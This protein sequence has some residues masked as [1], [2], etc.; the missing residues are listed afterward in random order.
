VRLIHVSRRTSFQSVSTSIAVYYYPIAARIFNCKL[1]Q[2]WR[3][4]VYRLSTINDWKRK[5]KRKREAKGK[6]QTLSLYWA[7]A[8]RKHAIRAWL[9]QSSFEHPHCAPRLY[10]DVSTSRLAIVVEQCFRLAVEC[11]DLPLAW[12]FGDRDDSTEEKQRS[13]KLIID[14]FF[15]MQLK[16]KSLT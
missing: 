1:T 8:Y 2:V 7:L 4:T 15:D 11:F 6:K 10:I 14:S 5:R 3:F 16:I 13:L 12:L 9:V